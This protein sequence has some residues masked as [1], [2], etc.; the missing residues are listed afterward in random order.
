MERELHAMKVRV[1]ELEA[2]EDEVEVKPARR[3]KRS[4]A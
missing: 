2:D 1:A 4:A 3:G